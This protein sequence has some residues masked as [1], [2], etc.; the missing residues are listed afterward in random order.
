MRLEKVTLKNFRC[1]K[2]ETV[3]K[4][5]HLNC[6]IGKND[7]G[8]STIM[9]ALDAFFNDN[10][11]TGDLSTNSDNDKIEITCEFTDI[12]DVLVLDTTIE[13]NPEE[14]GILNAE[15]NLEIVRVFK[16]QVNGA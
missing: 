13:T 8:K 11:D 6:L 12:P 14:E 9:E 15:G 3:F 1:Y 5:D 16:I 10:I 2:H 4:V 7:A